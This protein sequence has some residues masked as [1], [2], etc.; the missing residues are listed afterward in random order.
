MFFFF[1]FFHAYMP[2][3]F[4]ST[5]K[6]QVDNDKDYYTCF[7]LKAME[8][9]FVLSVNNVYNPYLHKYILQSG[10]DVTT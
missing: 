4:R 7:S 9:F 8:V 6:K 3:I 5:F 10:K 2:D 1:H